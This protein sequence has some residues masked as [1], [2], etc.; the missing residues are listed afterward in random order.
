VNTYL[1]HKIEE[2]AS[3]SAVLTSLQTRAADDK[4]DLTD[5]ERKTFDEIVER[6]KVLDEEI[7]RIKEFDHGAAKF[8]ELVGAQ[9]EA[10]ETAERA[11]ADADRKRDDQPAEDLATRA[12]FGQRFVESTAFRNY[13]G[14]GTSERVT[15]PGPATP[16]FRAAITTGDVGLTAYTG[17]VPQVWGGPG[18][19]QFTNSLLGLVGRVQTNQSA[20]LYLTWTPQ[21]PGN[22]PVVAEGDLKP[23]AVMDAT[24]AT[25]ALSTYAHYKAVTRQALEDIP[26]VQ[27]IVQNRLLSGVNTALE[28]A[29]VAAMVA[30][31]LP[32]VDGDGN[33]GAA[34]RYGIATVESAGF[35][36]NAVVLNPADAAM[37]D[38]DT[39]KQTNNGAVRIGNVWGLPIVSNRSVAQGTATVGDF[40]TGMT[41]F[42]RG[43]TDVY[44]SDSHADFFLRNQLVVLAEAR[45]AFAATEP[46]ALCECIAG[47]APVAGSSGSS[48]SSAS[49][50]DDGRRRK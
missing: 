37:L 30:A 3:Q 23:E 14:A 21:P 40:K 15:L 29:A 10:E 33:L 41:W 39:Y 16:E 24:E 50:G 44:M 42:D 1:R 43:T 26:Q 12:A 9:R 8:A 35:K 11:H 19:P 18:A 36:P 17:P 22:A 31:S 34:V 6:L 2:R 7:A 13:R 49:E 4:R 27:T 32:S 38:F 5:S 25:I 45:A 20:V 47:T 48:G 46:A 28:A